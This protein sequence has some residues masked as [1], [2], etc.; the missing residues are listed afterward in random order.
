MLAPIEV[1]RSYPPHDHTLAGLLASRAARDP[2]R[3]F[4]LYEGRA[5]SYAEFS[6]RVEAAACALAARGIGAGERVALMAPNRRP[7]RKSTSL[8]RSATFSR[9]ARAANSIRATS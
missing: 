6:H 5:L 4:L 8:P 1:I 7:Q 2:A 3:A 9:A